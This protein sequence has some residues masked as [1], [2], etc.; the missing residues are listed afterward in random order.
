MKYEQSRFLKVYDILWKASKIGV[1]HTDFPL[2]EFLGVKYR[3]KS[4]VLVDMEDSD[5]EAGDDH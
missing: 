4:D 3:S 2:R 5:F 1:S